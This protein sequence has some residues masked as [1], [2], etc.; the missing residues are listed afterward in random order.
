MTRHDHSPKRG[1]TLVEVLVALTILAV[2]LLPVTIGFWQ[3]LVVTNE[4]SLNAAASS[5]ARAELEELKH[6]DFAVLDS[7]PRE[8]RDLKPGDGFFEV[9]TAVEV[10]RPNDSVDSG[11]K[12]AEVSVYRAGGAERLA[13]ATTYLT[14]FGI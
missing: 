3:S 1:F 9:T 5:I 6:T 13:I 4:S 2:V 11:L 14:P 8:T 10:V 7:T 12:K